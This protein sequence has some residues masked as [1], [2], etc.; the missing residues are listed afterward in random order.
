MFAVLCV[1][2]GLVVGLVVAR[3]WALLA[4]VAIG[5][6]FA[7]GGGSET[8]PAWFLGVMSGILAG[9]GIGAGVSLRSGILAGIRLYKE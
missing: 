5:V 9:I 4:A 2:V 3:W 7:A 6:L 1:G 8:F